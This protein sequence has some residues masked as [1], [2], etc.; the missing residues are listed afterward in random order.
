MCTSV[1][2]NVGK[3][4]FGKERMCSYK[5]THNSAVH[6]R[7]YNPSL[8]RWNGTD[9]YYQH[10][11]PYLAMANNPVSFVDPDGGA[12]KWWKWLTG[13]KRKY[14]V[15]PRAR[16]GGNGDN[17]SGAGNDFEMEVASGYVNEGSGGVPGS[18]GSSGGES[19]SGS[20]SS[21]SGGG[22]GGGGSQSGTN[23]SAPQ[24]GGRPM[25]MND[26]IE[27]MDNPNYVNILMNKNPALAKLF[28]C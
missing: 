25:S 8:G 12:P 18:S 22:G 28:I 2:D 26:W 13:D 4:G 14:D 23:S 3:V 21:S 10:H 24:T 11:S 27:K 16:R 20:G 7:M 9:P 5:H 6:I 17:V 19:S 1:L 15:G